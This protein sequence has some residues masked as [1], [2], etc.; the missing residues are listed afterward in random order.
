MCTINFYITELYE[1]ICELDSSESFS[2]KRKNI[3]YKY[4]IKNKGTEYGFYYDRTCEIGYIH[5]SYL[6]N[7]DLGRLLVNEKYRRKGYARLLVTLGVLYAIYKKCYV[8]VNEDMVNG[9]EFHFWGPLGIKKGQHL[10][11]HSILKNILNQVQE[12]A[13]KKGVSVDSDAIAVSCLHASGGSV[14]PQPAPSPFPIPAAMPTPFPT[15]RPA[16]RR[17][18]FG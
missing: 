3:W 8:I 1:A 7:V 16:G 15:L 13:K 10:S 12:S 5:I 17:V 18:S 2:E 11:P 4:S 14:P 9:S 6:K